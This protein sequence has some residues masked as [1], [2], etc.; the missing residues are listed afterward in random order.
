MTCQSWFPLAAGK[1]AAANQGPN[2]SHFA[3]PEAREANGISGQKQVVTGGGRDSRST[4]FAFRSK[5][6]STE[7]TARAR[8]T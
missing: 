6:R 7:A 3:P 8:N 5:Q 4:R 2:A 1:Y